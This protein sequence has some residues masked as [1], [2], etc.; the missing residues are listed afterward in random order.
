MHWVTTCSVIWY[1]FGYEKSNSIA[2]NTSLQS[3]SERFRRLGFN[4]RT[5][6]VKRQVIS[7]RTNTTS[8]QFPR[9]QRPNNQISTDGLKIYKTLPLSV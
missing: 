8:V 6:N 9:Y 7:H 2:L 3:A 5:L 4:L 1:I